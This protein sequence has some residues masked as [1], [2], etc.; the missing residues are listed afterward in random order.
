MTDTS[1]PKQADTER[2][3][4]TKRLRQEMGS[5]S[6]VDEE[7]SYLDL[8]TGRVLSSTSR[9]RTETV[10]MSTEMFDNIV[11]KLS[12]IEVC[13]NKL[14][15]LDKLDNI[16]ADVAKLNRKMSTFEERLNESEKKIS[17]MEN[18]VSFISNKYDEI[19]KQS[20]RI[21][22][23]E[24]EIERNKR[25]NQELRNAIE[26][27]KAVNG[28]LK[29]NLID[30][31]C[32]SM[33][34]NL[35]FTNIPYSDKENTEEVITEFLDAKLKLNHIRI[36]RAHR[37]K[38]RHERRQNGIV[39]PPPIVVKF[40]FFKDREAVRRSGRLLAGTR[41]GI[42][43]QFPEEIEQRRKQ[44]YPLLRQAK[45][46]KKRAVLVKDKLFVEG[47][48]VRPSSSTESRPSSTR[49]ATASGGSTGFVR[50]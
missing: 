26:D 4:A 30:L 27:L 34:D 20:S 28:T 8:D 37:L 18:S 6:S 5:S 11:Q 2:R 1:T 21:V 25:D 38:G 9:R 33:R 36:E 15:K 48:E 16:E 47:A 45:R 31:Q 10:T 23:A 13:C 50:Q 39:Q 29:E 40:S 49:D 14:D 41:Y 35:I 22:D 17:D 24:R 12:L 3:Q 46:D 44:L 32:R 19:N 43:E 42:H 7:L